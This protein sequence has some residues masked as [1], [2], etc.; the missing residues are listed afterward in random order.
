MGFTVKEWVDRVT[1]Y[2]TRR[3]LIKSDGSSEI[4]TVERSEGTVSQ[5][6]DAFSAENMNDLEQRVA[7]TFK[8]VLYIVS[9]DSYP[10]KYGLQRGESE[11]VDT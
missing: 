2:P 11:K 7:N 5:E 9:F 3:R 1:E 8:V 6:G 4:V 10:E